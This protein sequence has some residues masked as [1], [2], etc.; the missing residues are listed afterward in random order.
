MGRSRAEQRVHAHSETERTMDRLLYDSEKFSFHVFQI[1][2][3]KRRRNRVCRIAC[4]SG[5][6]AP[7]WRERQQGFESLLIADW[8]NSN[9]LVSPLRATPLRIGDG[10]A[11][12]WRGLAGHSAADW[13]RIGEL[14]GL[15]RIGERKLAC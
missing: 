2:I 1:L 4:P 10:L 13:R 9:R 5:H 8:W 6:S 7:D 15:A 12:D 11:T 14:S 3:L